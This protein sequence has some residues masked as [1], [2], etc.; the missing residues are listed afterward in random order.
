MG[1]SRSYLKPENG[2]LDRRTGWRESE[3]S[4]ERLPKATHRVSAS[5]SIYRKGFGFCLISHKSFQTH[6]IINRSSSVFSV[7]SVVSSAGFRLKNTPMNPQHP[8][9]RAQKQSKGS[10]INSWYLITLIKH[11]NQAKARICSA[12]WRTGFR[13][14]AVESLQKVADAD[15]DVGVPGENFSPCQSKGSGINSWYL[16]PEACL[17]IRQ[18]HEFA[19]HFDALG[20]AEL[21]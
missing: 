8:V 6:R 19:P 16:V 14:V 2:F 11:L 3:R 5:E 13:G 12:F 20:F 9:F 17:L 1:G 15:E 21:R 4:G 10:G 18:K 7:R